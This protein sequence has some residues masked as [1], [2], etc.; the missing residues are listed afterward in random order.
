ML[1]L[2]LKLNQNN[3]RISKKEKSHDIQMCTQCNLLGG[4]MVTDEISEQDFGIK[5]SPWQL[6]H[7]S[8]ICVV[9]TGGIAGQVACP[10]LQNKL[11]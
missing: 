9:T 7:V 4:K 5:F 11:S 6:A 3:W 2:F 8:I 1:K 10:I